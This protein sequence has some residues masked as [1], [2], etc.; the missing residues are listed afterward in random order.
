MISPTRLARKA[1]TIAL[2]LGAL[3][4]C[5]DMVRQLQLARDF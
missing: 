3:L 4:L 2:W 1:A 5:L